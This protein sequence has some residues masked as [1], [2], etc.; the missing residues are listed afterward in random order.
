M[1]RGVFCLEQNNQQERKLDIF[2]KNEK[3]A[4]AVCKRGFF[5]YLK[6]IRQDRYHNNKRVYFF[7]N[8]DEVKR[9]IDQEYAK[10]RDERNYQI[11]MQEDIDSIN[12]KHY[13]N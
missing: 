13:S 8:T 11:R 9:V 1:L 5:K 2:V 3:I 7:D 10:Y 6:A 4:E 12:N